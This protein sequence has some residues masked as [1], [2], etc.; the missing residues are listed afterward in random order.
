MSATT[1]TRPTFAENLQ[2]ASSR[3]KSLLTQLNLYYAGVALLALINLYLLVQIGFT[4]RRANSQDA[5]ALE[6]QTVAMKTAEIATKPLEGLDGKLSKAT[7]ESD[8][9]YAK[10]LPTAYSEVVAE[11]GALSKQQG[12]KMARVQYAYSP[13]MDGAA[14]ALTEIRMDASFNGDYRPLVL[15]I[16]SLERDKMFFLIRGVTLAGQSSGTVGL[17]LSLTTYLRPVKGAIAPKPAQDSSA[18]G[19]AG[20]GGAR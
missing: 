9:F 14:G 3:A 20:E 18:P 8:A 13:V 16:N 6:Q 19:A 10:R 2:S 15:F 1:T 5:A 7:E 4:W 12:V 17:R 11:L